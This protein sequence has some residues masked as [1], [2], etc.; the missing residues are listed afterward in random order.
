M[1]DIPYNIKEQIIDLSKRIPADRRSVFISAAKKR[2]DG[3]STSYTAKWAIAGMAIGYLI[4]LLPFFEDATEIGGLLGAAIGQIKD[5][6]VKEEAERL[7]LLIEE[8][9]REAMA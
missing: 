5:Q 1:P 9:F 8:S 4:D 2:L 3:V 7:K 6:K